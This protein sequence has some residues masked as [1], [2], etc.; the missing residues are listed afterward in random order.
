MVGGFGLSLD[1]S[2]SVASDELELFGCRLGQLLSLFTDRSAK[3]RLTSSVVVQQNQHTLPISLVGR[4]LFPPSFVPAFFLRV[5]P[6]VFSSLLIVFAILK[7]PI[8]GLL[9]DTSTSSD[10][11]G[12]VPRP[13][14]LSA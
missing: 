10:L 6:A 4:V 3:E 1:W 7:I 13:G 5:Q 8:L 12:V 11:D 9:H 2:S 14:A